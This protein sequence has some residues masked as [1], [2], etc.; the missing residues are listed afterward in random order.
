MADIHAT[1]QILGLVLAL[2]ADIE[3]ISAQQLDGFSAIL[4]FVPLIPK[5]G[6]ALRDIKQVVP[7][8]RDLDDNERAE[9]KAYVQS[10][11]DLIDDNVEVAIEMALSVAIDLSQLV[12]ALQ[13][14][15]VV[16]PIG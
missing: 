1:K 2:T 8:Y 7:E 5:I 12:Q 3:A 10:E 13:G 15:Q 6:P 9:L 16:H 14:N 4:K 11:L